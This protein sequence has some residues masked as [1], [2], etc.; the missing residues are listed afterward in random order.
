MKDMNRRVT[1]CMF[2]FGCFLLESCVK[3][4]P[5]D[6]G[7][8]EIPVVNCLLTNDSIQQL[9]LTQSVKI[10]NPYYFKEI[11][12]AEISLSTDSEVVGYFDRVS[13]G[14]WQLNYTPVE[15]NVYELHVKL[16]DGRELKASTTMPMANRF[17]PLIN[18]D[19]YP[20]KN[21]R[22][23]S[24][25]FP[26]WIYI[27]TEDTPAQD[28]MHPLP[29]QKARLINNLG[30][31]H[32]WIDRFNKHENMS[33][34][35]ME[36]SMP[37]Y[38]FYLRVQSFPD[39]IQGSVSF[40]IQAGYSY[41]SYIYFRTVSE[42]YDRYLKSSI[43]KMNVYQ[44]ENDPVYMFDESKVYSNIQ[45][46]TGIFGAYNEQLTY[47]NYNDFVVHNGKVFFYNKETSPFY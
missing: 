14:T 7:Q 22:Q 1:Y 21:F 17:D 2:L 27:L 16:S 9:S 25:D 38:D 41:Y 6:I 43:Q 19:H 34:I 10:T 11:K 32:P 37:F 8:S 12:D 46:G 30:T 23:L 40:G 45:N 13:Y 44:D 5:F 39:T 18:E 29:N 20:T 3:E 36:V 33:D 28:L 24:A 42:E 47:Y 4:L 26:C 35:E 15:G 31:N